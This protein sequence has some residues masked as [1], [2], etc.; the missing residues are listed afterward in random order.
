[1]ASNISQDL[2]EQKNKQRLALRKEYLKQLTNPHD[3]GSGHI[4]DPAIQRWQSMKVTRIDWFRETPKTI[5]RGLGLIVIPLALSIYVIKNDRDKKE[6]QYRTGQ[7]AYKDRLF[8][9]Q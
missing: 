7:V 1:M 3:P 9:F 6:A 5:L 4:F 2:I 8:K